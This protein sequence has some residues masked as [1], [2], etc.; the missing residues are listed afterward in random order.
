MNCPRLQPAISDRSSKKHLQ[1]ANYRA[2]SGGTE[3]SKTHWQIAMANALGSFA[4]SFLCIAVLMNAMAIS[5]T[6]IASE[7]SGKGLNDILA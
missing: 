3:V 4:F 1:Y 6:L 7:H 5:V 2:V